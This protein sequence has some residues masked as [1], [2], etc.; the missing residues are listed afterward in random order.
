MS[1]D[2]IS[3]PTLSGKIRR[4]VD[5]L[6]DVYGQLS[7]RD[8]VVVCY[9]PDAREYAAHVSVGLTKRG[10]EHG[11]V[12]MRPLGDCCSSGCSRVAL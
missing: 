4:G 9:S 7:A 10:R 11:A 12:P 2:V 3:E 6:L 1:M 5:Q 8:F